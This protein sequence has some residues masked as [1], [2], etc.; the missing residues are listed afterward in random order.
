LQQFV[1]TSPWDVVNRRPEDARADSIPVAPETA[2]PRW[3]VSSPVPGFDGDRSS[4]GSADVVVADGLGQ[5]AGQLH[6]TGIG[7][8]V[9]PRP[10]AVRRRGVWVRRC[11]HARPGRT[12]ALLRPSPLRTGLACFHASGSSKPKG[13]AG[14][15]ECRA[16]AGVG[17]LPSLA[18]C[19]HETEG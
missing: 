19:V 13:R 2:G 5:R 8:G 6:D 15:Q 7:R 1:I 17:V 14:G 9:P 12:G 16:G 4:P 18:V 11:G 3:R 10:F